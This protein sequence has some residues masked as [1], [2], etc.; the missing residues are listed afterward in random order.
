LDKCYIPITFT[1]SNFDKP[2]S[3]DLDVFS[4]VIGLKRSENFVFVPP[5]GTMR[6]GLA[7]L[8][9]TD[10]KNTSIP[11]SE[12]VNLQVF[13][14]PSGEVTAD[15]SVDKSLSET[16]VQHGIILTQKVVETQPAKEP[17]ATANITQS[18][19]ASDSAEEQ[20]NQLKP[21]DAKKHVIEQNVKE[22]VEVAELNSMGDVIFEQQMDEYDQ[23]QNVLDDDNQ[24]TFLGPMYVDMGTDSNVFE[25]KTVSRSFSVIQEDA[26][27]DKADSDL[28]SIPDDTIDSVDG[29]DVV[30]SDTYDNMNSEPKVNLSTSEEASADH[31][32]DYSD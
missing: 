20:G 12:L 5:K 24:I 4:T 27:L 9:L 22:E 16:S 10:E 14:P 2:L 1:L 26:A 21:T 25:V 3:I 15:D 11:S 29:F 18:L 30:D 31:L 23:N 7:T 6:A 17:V 8:G 28:V 32:L 19:D 13:L